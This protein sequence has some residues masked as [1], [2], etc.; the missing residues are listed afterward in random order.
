MATV[1]QHVWGTAPAFVGPRHELREKLLLR[2]L[3]AVGPGHDILNAGAGLGSFTA[4]LEGRGFSVT[5]TDVSEPALDHL[6]ERVDGPVVRADLTELPFPAES[7][8]AVVLGEVLEHVED[9][10]A[11]LAEVHRVLRPGGALAL[12]VP[13]NPAWFG[14]SDAWAG[15]FRRYARA[16]LV[17]K[18]TTARFDVIRCVGWGFPVSAA[19]HRTV[20]DRRAERL[21]GEGRPHGWKAV[22]VA[23]LRLALQIDRAFVG[24]E[25]GALG[26]LLTARR[27]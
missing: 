15:H 6:F 22:A 16:D 1:A 4:L 14:P 27:G 23:G 20:F 10:G 17:E 18:V 8:D 19:Y 21:A 24:V 25:R 26:F 7:F 9:D 12:S 11:A 3:L 5:S 13:A 2:E